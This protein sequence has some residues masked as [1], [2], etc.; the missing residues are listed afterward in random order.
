MFAKYLEQ[1]EIGE[2]WTSK[3]RTITEADLVNFSSFSGDW[4][5]L[6]TDKEYAAKTS[7]KQRIAHGMSVLSIATG[8]ILLEP[9]IVEAF[10]GMDHVRFTNPTFIGDTLHLEMSVCNI[11]EKDNGKGIVSTEMEIK[12]QTGETVAVAVVKML[13]NKSKG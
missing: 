7:F 3:G 13:V 4:F 11:Q 12:K 10:Y 1:Y 9:G 6:H 5:P 8:L 2:T